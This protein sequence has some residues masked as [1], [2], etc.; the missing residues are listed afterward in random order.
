[1]GIVRIILGIKCFMMA[2]FL[3]LTQISVYEE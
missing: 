3:I 1:M 2:V